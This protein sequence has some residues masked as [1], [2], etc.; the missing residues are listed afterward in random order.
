MQRLPKMST[1]IWAM[2]G[3]WTVLCGFLTMHSVGLLGQWKQRANGFQR[4][5]GY[6]ARELTLTQ[7]Q[8]QQTRADLATTRTR[9]AATQNQLLNLQIRSQS[10]AKKRWL[11]SPGAMVR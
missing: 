3:V 1:P 6:L 9:L 8:L 11:E 5:N 7:Q 4:N 10:P 2:L